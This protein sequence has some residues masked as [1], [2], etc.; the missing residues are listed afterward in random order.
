[1]AGRGC[2]WSVI[3]SRLPGR[4]GE[5]VRDRYVNVLDPC[6]IKT[7]WTAHED[8]ILFQN[9]RRIGNKWAE[10]GK[11][12][13]GRSE[14]SIKNRFH[15]KKTTERRKQNRDLVLRMKLQAD[16]KLQG[17]M[18]AEV[19]LRPVEQQQHDDSCSATSNINEH[20]MKATTM[21]NDSAVVVEL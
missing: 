14:N 12:L 4:R 7:P 3:A 16:T 5:A 17:S 9:Q 13:P 10:I 20:N 18:M 6:L 11:L 2:Q 15:N 19:E 8:E 1:M 21:T